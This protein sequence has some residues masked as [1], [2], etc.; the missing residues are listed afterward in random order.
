[1][2]TAQDRDLADQML[3]EALA[4]YEADNPGESG[5]E[6]WFDLAVATA[7]SLVLDERKPDVARDFCQRTFGHIPHDLK[8]YL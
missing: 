3:K 7:L 1:M 4:D 2:I 6:V 8:E 5:V